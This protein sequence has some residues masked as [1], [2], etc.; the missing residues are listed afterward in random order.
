MLLQTK[1]FEKRTQGRGIT[2]IMLEMV[3][4]FG[5]EIGI[6][7]IILSKK[8]IKGILE[9]KR[10]D[11]DTRANLIKILDKGGLCIVADC[12]HFITAYPISNKRLFKEK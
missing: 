8:T 12:E 6:D 5:T 10:L 3:F 1:H 2:K 4:K 11:L 7:K 9:K